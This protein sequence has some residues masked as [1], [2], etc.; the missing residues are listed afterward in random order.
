M[1]QLIHNHGHCYVLRMSIIAN[2][3]Y[4][5]RQNASEI[6]WVRVA[7]PN[8]QCHRLILMKCIADKRNFFVSTGVFFT[9]LVSK[10]LAHSKS[11]V[12]LNQP[13]IQ[14][15]QQFQQ[16]KFDFKDREKMSFGRVLCDQLLDCFAIF[17]HWTNKNRTKKYRQLGPFRFQLKLF[18]FVA[19]QSLCSFVSIHFGW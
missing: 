8:R 5:R 4:R 9:F 13:R 1:S 12:A 11:C 15:K 17:V 19:R 18:G 14:K 2:K 16:E 3:K 7:V 10:L 6:E